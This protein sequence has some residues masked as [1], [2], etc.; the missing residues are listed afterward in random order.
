MGLAYLMSTLV[1]AGL[2]PLSGFI[3]KFAMLGPLL[4][5]QGLG[6]APGTSPGRPAGR[7]WRC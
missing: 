5:P 1:I 6:T 4:D 2:P 3:G 7:C